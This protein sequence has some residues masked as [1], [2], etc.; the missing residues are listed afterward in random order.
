[1]GPGLGETHQVRAAPTLRALEQGERGL[2]RGRGRGRARRGRDARRATHARRRRR[3][4]P[5][6]RAE[7]AGVRRERRRREGGRHVAGRQVVTL[8]AEWRRARRGRREKQPRRRTRGTPLYVLLM[9][10]QKPPMPSAGSPSLPPASA[11]PDGDMSAPPPDA[12]GLDAASAELEALGIGV[13]VRQ[14]PFPTGNFPI[15]SPSST[16][17]TS[18]SGH[19]VTSHPLSPLPLPGGPLQRPSVARGADPPATP[20]RPPRVPPPRR[21]GPGARRGHGLDGAQGT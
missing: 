11:A 19:L 6:A 9:T 15:P 3:D 16:H 7:R 20:P 13:V 5:R 21:S 2:F 17:E 4:A 1:M 8:V 12:A 18:R 14:T 10:S